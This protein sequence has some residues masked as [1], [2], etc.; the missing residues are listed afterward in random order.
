MAT[1]KGTVEEIAVGGRIAVPLNS[2]LYG[3]RAPVPQTV[4]SA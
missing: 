1:K 4:V 3:E 2:K